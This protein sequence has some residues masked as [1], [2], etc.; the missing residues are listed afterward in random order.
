MFSTK[1]ERE[2]PDIDPKSNIKAGLTDQL[3]SLLS[4]AK[5][6]GATFWSLYAIEPFQHVNYAPLLILE[7][8]F[9]LE[10]KIDYKPNFMALA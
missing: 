3:T 1:V 6:L 2:R 4:T 5:F 9:R 10:T 8:Q 7:L